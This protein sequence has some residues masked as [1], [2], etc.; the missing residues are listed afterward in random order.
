MVIKVL[1]S[2]VKVAGTASR[3]ISVSNTANPKV[4]MKLAE[5]I[6]KSSPVVLKAVATAVKVLK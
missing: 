4:A 1:V 6:A 3:W 5:G 2:M